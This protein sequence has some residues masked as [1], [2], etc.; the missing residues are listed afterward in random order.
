MR[1]SASFE[2]LRARTS[3]LAPYC[4]RFAYALTQTGAEVFGWTGSDSLARSGAK[5]LRRSLVG[6]SMAQYYPP[7]LRLKPIREVLRDSQRDLLGLHPGERAVEADGKTPVFSTETL[8]RTR[9]VQRRGATYE[10]RSRVW[11]REPDPDPPGLMTITDHAFEARCVSSIAMSLTPQRECAGEDAQD[12]SRDAE[13]RC[14]WI[15]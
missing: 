9:N 8:S 10:L 1:T 7:L 15:S 14:A 6:P 4:Y 5:Y 3:P 12:R 2:P 13:K 11:A